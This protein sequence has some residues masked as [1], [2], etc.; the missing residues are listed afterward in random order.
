MAK[1]VPAFQDSG[2][3]IVYDA[4]FQS[5]IHANADQCH[6]TYQRI[7]ILCE[8]SDRGNSRGGWFQFADDGST[9]GLDPN[10]MFKGEQ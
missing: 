6:H 7:L 5:T 1:S 4:Q 8:V 10:D 9:Y 2:K 3:H